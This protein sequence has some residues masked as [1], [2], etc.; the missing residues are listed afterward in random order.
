MYTFFKEYKLR[1]DSK[2]NKLKEDL[3]INAKNLYDGREMIIK[4]FRGKLFPLSGP[5]NY[6]H[7]TE[8]DSQE[9]DSKKDKVSFTDKTYKS[10][11]N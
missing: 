11:M 2:Y 10:L 3:F 8:S 4:A 6:P 9:S 5:S 1:K 7:Y